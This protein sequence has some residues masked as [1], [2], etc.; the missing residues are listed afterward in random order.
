MRARL[1]SD[2]DGRMVLEKERRR[3]GRLNLKMLTVGLAAVLVAIGA[4]GIQ[5]A[6][7]SGDNNQFNYG[8]ES[9]YEENNCNPYDD[10]DFPGL[11]TQNRTGV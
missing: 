7:A 10:E 11:D 6:I 4:S 9:Y 5:A 2:S 8:E 3:E 1:E